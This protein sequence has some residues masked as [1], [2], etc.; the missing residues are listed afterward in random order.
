MHDFLLICLIQFRFLLFSSSGSRTEYRRM[1]DYYTRTPAEP[2]NKENSPDIY[3][4]RS[5]VT[6]SPE[7]STYSTNG[8]GEATT[9]PDGNFHGHEKIRRRPYHQLSFTTY[10]PSPYY[11]NKRYYHN[12]SQREFKKNNRR[13]AR[14]HSNS[15]IGT[16]PNILQNKQSV[17]LPD[18]CAKSQGQGE[19]QSTRSQFLFNEGKLN[20]LL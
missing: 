14:N 13:L 11:K 15:S 6:N 5:S 17:L 4:T 19:L 20:L 3:Y 18:R 1:D 2:I 16:D 8:E 7:F 9:T 10:S 12:Q